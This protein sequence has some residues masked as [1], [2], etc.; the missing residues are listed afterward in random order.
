MSC[1]SH[2]LSETSRSV[3]TRGSEDV[4]DAVSSL[5]LLLLQVEG[6][7]VQG[8]GW[9]CIE[10]LVWGDS[11]HTWVKPGTLHTRGPGVRDVWSASCISKHRWQ[12]CSIH[13]TCAA[14]LRLGH[15][16]EQTVSNQLTPVQCNWKHP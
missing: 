9:T 16:T 3:G 7:F 5:R 15:R 13:I 4:H 8:M 6:G 14:M 10:E 11:D 12:A 2:L 1:L